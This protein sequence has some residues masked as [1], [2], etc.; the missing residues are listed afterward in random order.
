MR[1]ITK[2]TVVILVAGATGLGYLSWRYVHTPRR[3]ALSSLS[4]LERVLGLSSK[5]FSQDSD[6]ILNRV[7]IPEAF[8]RR[9]PREQ[10]EF[11]RKALKDEVSPE[12]IA[13]L[14]KQG[15]FGSLLE[16]FPEKGPIWA[17]QMGVDPMACVA[18]ASGEIP[19]QAE[20]VLLTKG[21]KIVRCNN[22][23]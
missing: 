8:Q 15:R 13:A 17:K 4:E 11:L 10:A 7:S 14:K 19:M 22:V 16:I 6:P 1:W 23:R 2:R 9:S 3:M 12:G 5:S 18:F 20:V 21:Y